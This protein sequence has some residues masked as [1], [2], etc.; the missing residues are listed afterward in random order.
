MKFLFLIIFTFYFC[1][2]IGNGMFLFKNGLKTRF[3]S[4]KHGNRFNGN[5]IMN[6]GWLK[7]CKSPRKNDLIP[8]NILKKTP[9]IF[10]FI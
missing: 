5:E 8:R 3:K 2:Q 4:K 1:T 7:I 10:L 9:S 6:E